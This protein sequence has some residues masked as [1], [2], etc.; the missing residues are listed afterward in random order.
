[1]EEALVDLLLTAMN[2]L[3][4]NDETSTENKIFWE[5]L[6]SQLVFFVLYQYARFAGLVRL[7][8]DK[9]KCL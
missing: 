5:H 4:A 3:E 7:L 8:H 2:K 6:S 1:L 9:V